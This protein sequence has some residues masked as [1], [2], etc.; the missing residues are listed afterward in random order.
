MKYQLISDIRLSIDKPE[1]EA[2]TKAKKELGL[3]NSTPAFVYRKSLDTRKDR[4]SF[5]YTVA[6]ATE[7]ID[8]RLHA[9]PDY[10]FPAPVSA[11]KTVPVIGFGPAGMFCAWL[12]AKC[13]HKPLVIERGQPIEQR[14]QDVEGFWQ[15]GVLNPESNVQFGEGG[16]GTFSDGKLTTRIN[17][18][19]C[20]KILETFVSFGA[21]EEILTLAKP[22]IGTDRLREVVKAM[23]KEIIALGGEVR[24]GAKLTGLFFDNGKLNGIEINGERFDTDTV[25]LAIGNGARDTYEMLLNTPLAIEAKPFSVGFRAEHSQEALNARIY[26]KYNGNPNLGAADYLFSHVTDK[27]TSEAVYSFCMCPGGQVVNASSLPG[28]LTTNGMSHYARDGK[29]ANAAILASVHPGTVHE[30]LKLQ[31]SIEKAAYNVALGMGPATTGSDFLNQQKPSKLHGPQATFLPGVA[32]FD[33]NELF[34]S[35]VSARLREGFAKFKE[36]ILGNEPALLTAPE[37][38]TSAP[39]RILRNGET[40]QAL[41]GAGLYP[42]G[43]GAGYAGGI[44]SSAVDGLRIAEQ[45]IGSET[46]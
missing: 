1:E 11:P 20:R 40:L 26:G 27:T 13:G 32:P 4:F 43:E 16:A 42:C 9:F 33:I 6:V 23:R 45:I 7:K 17:D 18:P 31:E 44:M 46:L 15:K 24:F 22:H 29:N 34:P 10:Q 38:R 36:R 12:L 39:L 37:T 21:P 25:V 41:N 14:I 8:P 5:V 3:P 2:I 28:Q 30:G 35:S 19:R